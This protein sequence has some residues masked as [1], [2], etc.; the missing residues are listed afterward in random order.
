MPLAHDAASLNEIAANSAIA[1]RALVCEKL[2]RNDVHI[3]CVYPPSSVRCIL[4]CLA[5]FL[6]TKH[7]R[8]T[9]YSGPV[10]GE[11]VCVAQKTMLRFTWQLAANDF[12]ES[13]DV[14]L[15]CRHAD[16]HGVRLPKS[17]KNRLSLGLGL[18]AVDAL[19][20]A[21]IRCVREEL[22]LS[23]AV[24]LDCRP[25]FARTSAF[26]RAGMRVRAR[27]VVQTCIYARACARDFV[28]SRWVCGRPRCILN[29]A[30]YPRLPLGHRD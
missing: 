30:Q 21:A 18:P 16:Q 11:G 20:D 13:F 25:R 23:G 24:K 15:L 28:H 12:N 29:K 2:G 22:D 9:R 4:R 26:F 3:S 8:F 5:P 14:H 19:A 1:S 27:A 6:R 7:V 10:E 17:W